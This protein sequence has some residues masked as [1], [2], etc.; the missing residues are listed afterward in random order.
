[1]RTWM[2]NVFGGRDLKILRALLYRP[3]LLSGTRSWKAICLTTGRLNSAVISVVR[4]IRLSFELWIKYNKLSTLG[5][6]KHF[7][8]IIVSWSNL[9]CLAWVFSVLRHCQLLIGRLLQLRVKTCI[10]FW[11]TIKTQPVTGEEN[12][13]GKRE[14][15][16]KRRMKV[17]MRIKILFWNLKLT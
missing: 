9:S 2:K 15:G 3:W 1:M 13:H 4:G 8:E 5:H 17:W 12:C 7:T 16:L 14:R 11:D 10:W 6:V